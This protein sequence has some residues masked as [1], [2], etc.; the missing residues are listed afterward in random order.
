MIVPWGD[1]LARRAPA[2]EALHAPEL[3]RTVKHQAAEQLAAE[4]PGAAPVSADALAKAGLI[5]RAQRHS[6]ISE[7]FRII[8][9]KLLREAFGGNGVAAAARGNLIVVTSALPGEG[10]SFV[11]MNLAAGIARQGDRRVLLIDADVKPDSLGQIMGLSGAPGLFDLVRS[12]S[13]SIDDLIVPTTV[14]HLDILPPGTGAAE[15]AELFASKRMAELL[16][17]LGQRYADRPII[18]D[19]SPCLSSSNPHALAPWVGQIVVVVAAGSTHQGDVEAAL[20]LVQNCPSVSLLLN[21][22]AP[23]NL[24]SFGSYAYPLPSSA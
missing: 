12:G 14:E 4:K 10:K 6:R 21:K 17:E 19:S 5:D 8:Q 11:T 18:F 23:W 3:T 20:D 1:V 22:I 2:A 13:H 24:H 7:E 15:S 9:S 16:E